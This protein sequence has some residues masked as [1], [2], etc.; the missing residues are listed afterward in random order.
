[1]RNHSRCTSTPQHAE[2]IWYFLILQTVDFSVQFSPIK[3]IHLPHT[4]VKYDYF[5]LCSK[6]NRK[7]IN[8][9]SSITISVWNHK[10][11]FFFL[12]FPRLLLASTWLPTQQ[13]QIIKFQAHQRNKTKNEFSDGNTNRWRTLPLFSR[14]HNLKIFYYQLG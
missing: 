10:L 2:C 11:R 3:N 1:M 6:T 9:I 12:I 8:S 14:L 4:A 13:E 5:L 7:E